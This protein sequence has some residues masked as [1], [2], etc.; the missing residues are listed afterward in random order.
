MRYNHVRPNCSYIGLP[1]GDLESESLTPAQ[2]ELLKAAVGAGVY[3]EELS[4]PVPVK[5]AEV[6]RGTYVKPKKAAPVERGEENV[7]DKSEGN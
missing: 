6:S 1:T 7:S 2:Q 5:Q 3:A 4:A